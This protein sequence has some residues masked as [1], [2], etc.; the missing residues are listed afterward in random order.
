[1][2]AGRRG[3]YQR[4]QFLDEAKDDLRLVAERSREV[5]IEVLRLLKRL[6]AGQLTPRALHDFAKTGDLRDCGK[7]VVAVEGEPEH[8][9]VVHDVGGRLEVCEVVAVEDREG[10]LPYLLAGLRLGRIDDPIRRSDAQR[11][12]AR[13]RKLRG[14]E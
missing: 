12:V 13:I 5:A 10:D 8:R 3:P 4:V 11:R 1:M 2:S 9:I 14:P 6:D 7:I